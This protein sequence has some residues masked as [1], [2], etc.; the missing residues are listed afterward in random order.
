[1]FFAKH[2]DLVGLDIGSS[3]IKMIELAEL[4]GNK[5]R[6]KN[7][8]L[9][10]LSKDSII[11]GNMKNGQDVVSAIKRLTENLNIKNKNIAVSVSGHSII[12]KKISMSSMKDIELEENI[13]WEAEQYIPFT[14]DEV[15]IDF[16]TLGISPSAPDKL[17]V[18]LVAAKKVSVNEY[19]DIITEAG[20]NSIVMD[21][22]DF[23]LENMFE[24]NYP[25]EIEGINAIIDIGAGVININII[26]GG[27]YLF[28]RDIF[29]GGNHITAEIQKVFD[30]SYEEAETI[31]L[32]GKIE[33]IDNAGVI[34]IMRDSI[35]NFSKEIQKSIEFFAGSTDEV[36]N[37]I[38]ICGGCS[39]IKGLSEI[40]ENNLK[41]PV[42][43]IDP[44]K[45]I[46]FETKTFDP[47]YI[48][49]I[50]PRAAVGVGL[51]L[52]RIGDK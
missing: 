49:C 24:I 31:K 22:D 46:E 40:L 35:N 3:S 10:V 33:G 20:L 52:R 39:N 21:I 32:G 43:I 37:K 18:L 17:E 12:I 27:S 48:K 11:N 47:E 36:V 7:F 8:G 4:K 41:I 13:Q 34:N 19:A 1:M 38:F 2:D 16:Q 44:F 28:N 6:L 50:G 15:N 51:A 42:E 9:A 29:L 45:N 30:I 14:L 25:E 5:Y 23:A 26:K